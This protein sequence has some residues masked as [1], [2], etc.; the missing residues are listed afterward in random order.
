MVHLLPSGALLEITKIELD[1][2]NG[3]EDRVSNLQKSDGFPKAIQVLSRSYES[4]STSSPPPNH[5]HCSKLVTFTMGIRVG[6]PTL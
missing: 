3:V 1:E 6:S 4:P 5:P 2:T